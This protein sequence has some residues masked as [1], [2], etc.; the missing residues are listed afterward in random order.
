M[1]LRHLRYFVTVAEELHFGRA[2][3][4]LHIVQPALSKQISSL[5]AELGIKLFD[6][7]RRHVNLTEA[8]R[9]FFEEANEVLAQADGAMNRAR[10]VSRGEGGRLTI[11][12]IFPA[13]ADLLPR[14]LRRFRQHYPGVS[15]TVGEATNRTAMERIVSR[16]LHFAFMRLPIENRPELEQEIL[17]EE[18]VVLMVPEGHRLATQEVVRL[19]DAEDEDLLLIARGQ[20]PELHDY[21]VSVCNSAGFSPR[22][23]NEVNSMSMASGLVAGG[24]GVAFAPASGGLNAQR[25]VVYRDITG[26]APRLI[27]GAVW[28]S[29]PRPR[30]LDNFL[31]LRPWDTEPTSGAPAVK[32]APVRASST[33]RTVPRPAPVRLNPRAR[34]ASSTG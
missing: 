26:P 2:S 20:E 6:R 29:G 19:K 25:G 1:E 22:V 30:V 17:V 7:D 31:R 5:E 13:L 21:Y 4:R 34:P 33:Q 18:P 9:V 32:L 23:A 12:F 11:G 10:A 28:H 16:N 3:E 24:L 14:S 15:L 8:G 27:M